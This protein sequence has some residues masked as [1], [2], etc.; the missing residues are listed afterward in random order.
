MKRTLIGGVLF[1]VLAWTAWRFSVVGPPPEPV[2]ARPDS[3]STG[4]RAARLFYASPDGDSLVSE[5]RDLAESGVLHERVASLIGELARGPRGSAVVALPSGT[6]LLH[7]Y[8]DDRG[9]MTLDLSP[10]FAR[11]FHGGTTAEYMAV[12]SLLRTLGANVPEARRVLIECGG[13]PLA[14]AGGHL[15][16]DQPFDVQDW[17]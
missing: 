17:P 1:A 5:S 10:D 4:L 11:G 15:P 16:C 7:V 9:L 3:V 12:A 13:Q 6:S 2:P 8:L 14:T